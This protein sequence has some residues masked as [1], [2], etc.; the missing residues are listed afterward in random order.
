MKFTV[1]DISSVKKILHIEIPE[2]TVTQAY[3]A[4]Y[5]E[6]K[7]TSKIKGFRQGKV[8]RAVLER[9]FG[10]TVDADVT[11]QLMQ[12]AFSETIRE[13]ALPIVSRPTI[14]PPAIKD[15]AAYHFDATVEVAPE[16]ADIDF[17]G[18][19]IK[20]T[21]YQVSDGEMDAQLTMLQRR[22][23]ERKTIE[24]TERT[25]KDGDFALIDYEGFK[26][27]APFAETARTEN[28]SLKIGDGQIDKAFDEQ[29]IGMKPGDTREIDVT[30]PE[31]HS[32]EALQGYSIR[33]SVKLNEIQEETLP[34]ID[35]DMA[36][37]LGPFESIDDL[38]TKIRENLQ[39]GYDNRSE[40]E[41]N[42][43]IYE[44]LIDRTDFEL[45]ESL[46]EG[47]LDAIVAEAEQTFKYHNVDMEQTGMTQ[48]TLRGQY[49]STAEKQVRRHLILG[50]IIE[51]EKLELPDEVLEEGFEKMAQ[52]FQ[53]PAASIKAYYSSNPD[54]LDFFKHT[55]LEKEAVR[56]ILEHSTVEEIEPAADADS[57]SEGA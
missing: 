54:K 1:E 40:Q 46:V 12:D 17:K 28:F 38:K 49:R 35:D 47:E 29:I 25:L 2:E 23:A 18:I 11:S 51:Q 22:L 14:D 43:Q 26:D 34:A 50:K 39:Q 37:Q 19:E 15:K 32:N 8:P 33:F 6:L 24:D 41:L 45:P 48:E 30:F 10:K 20:K 9:R 4:A 57:A 31:T 56:L 27:G 13:T 7:K 55:L 36:K 44:A 52:A 42:E 16:I 53:Q 21:M 5:D 3:T